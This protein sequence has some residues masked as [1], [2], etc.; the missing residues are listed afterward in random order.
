MRNHGWL[1]DTFSKVIGTFRLIST[2]V[3]VSNLHLHLTLALEIFKLSLFVLRRWK[4]RST[5][6]KP[7]LKHLQS[8]D[9]KLS[10]QLHQPLD[11]KLSLQ[12]HRTLGLKASSQVRL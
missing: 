7:S 6:L 4:L 8:L 9:L 3:L 1:F 2:E 5:D 11:L 12:R 10:L